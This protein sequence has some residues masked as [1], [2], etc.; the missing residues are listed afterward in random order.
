MPTVND[1]EVTKPTPQQQST[2]QNW[3]IWT[4]GVSEFDW[5]YTQK[6][7]CLVL[8]GQVTVTDRPD[9]GRAVSFGP[10]DY[11]VFPVGL[12]CVWKVTKPVRKH[13]DFE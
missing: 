10:G 12:E 7:K 8:E 2:C 4:C 9:S 5:D 6:E 1:I 13:Y 3:P 11:V